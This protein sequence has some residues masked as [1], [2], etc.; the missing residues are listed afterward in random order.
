MEIHTIT[1]AEVYTTLSAQSDA[2]ID[3]RTHEE[4]NESHVDGAIHIP[5]DQLVDRIDEVRKFS[6]KVFFLCRSGGRSEIAA[7]QAMTQG[8]SDVY[9]VTGGMKAWKKSGTP[10][11]LAQ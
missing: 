4:W 11:S 6:G 10:F 9:N 2:L 7:L 3:V 1:P 5:L 8:V